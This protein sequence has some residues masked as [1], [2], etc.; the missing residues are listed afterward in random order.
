M[1]MRNISLQ[2]MQSY[3]TDILKEFDAFCN[4][5]GLTYYVGYG[6]LLGAIRHSG[7]IPWDDDIDVLMPREDY[8][9]LLKYACVDSAERYE[10]IGKHNRENWP[11]P[12]AKCVDNKTELLETDFNSGMVGI[13]VDI[14]PLDGLPKGKLA[15]KLHMAK[16][17]LFHYMLITVQKKSLKGGTALKTI[18]KHLVYPITKR[19]GVKYWVEKVDQ[20]GKK[21]AFDTS[22][23]IASQMIC[24]YG[25]RECMQRGLYKERLRRSFGKIETWIPSGYDEILTKLYGDYM[26]L[27]PEEKRV[28]HHIYNVRIKE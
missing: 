25:N 5:H 6:T 10:I 21:H 1:Q 8:E 24:V 23:N 7:F 2:E 12:F 4:E 18:V 15:T 20:L 28:T 16:V 27:P 17:K 11:Y 13:Y 3:V 9:K 22:K 19:Q 26:K 14:F